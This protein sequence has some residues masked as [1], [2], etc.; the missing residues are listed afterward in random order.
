MLA[1]KKVSI[2]S[3]GN[4]LD[5]MPSIIKS[6][7]LGLI[8]SYE[9]FL[10]KKMIEADS[11][12]ERAH[13]SA[14]S[15]AKAARDDAEVE[16]W[17]KTQSIHQE[18]A[19]LKQSIVGEIEKECSQVVIACLQKL[20]GETPA[21]AKVA[22]LISSLLE[23]YVAD[24]PAKFLVNPEQLELVVSLNQEKSI[25]VF[26]DESVEKDCVILKTEKSQFQSSFKGKLSLFIQSLNN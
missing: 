21:E 18:L 4:A 1:N 15:I 19:S 17:K 22:P 2:G 24:E 3:L 16:F 26:A 23:K 20:L 7:D 10:L 25:P 6:E 11:V 12:I 14:K 5:T 8:N 13:E 9:T